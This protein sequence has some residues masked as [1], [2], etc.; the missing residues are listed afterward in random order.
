MNKHVLNEEGKERWKESEMMFRRGVFG[1]VEGWIGVE[2]IGMGWV[3][4]LYVV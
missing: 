1:G 3:W 4:F 2:W